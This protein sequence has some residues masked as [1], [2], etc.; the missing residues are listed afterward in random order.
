[1]TDKEI[2]EAIANT[3]PKLFIIRKPLHAPFDL[4]R[5]DACGYTNNVAD[6]WQVPED[7]AKKHSCGSETDSDRVIYE[8]VP[9]PNYCKDLNAMHYVE[10]A[11][12]VQFNGP[13]FYDTLQEIVGRDMGID[14]SEPND[15]GF[16]GWIAHATA[17]QRA[18][19]FLKTLDQW[20]Y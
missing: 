12:V 1:M 17:R 15:R 10:M 5:P 14:L 8:R 4:Y 18:E 6:A 20:V 16:S 19:A 13:E 2:N 3:M 7:V 11:Q 9:T